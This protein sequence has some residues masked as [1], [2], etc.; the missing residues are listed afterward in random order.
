MVSS[1]RTTEES[2]AILI[3]IIRKGKNDRIGSLRRSYK[4]NYSLEGKGKIARRRPQ[5]E[6]NIGRMANEK[7]TETTEEIVFEITCL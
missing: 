4:A 1:L 7:L 2:K 5:V 3:K 6:D